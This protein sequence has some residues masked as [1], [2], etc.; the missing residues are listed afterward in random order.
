MALTQ[1]VFDPSDDAW[2][3]RGVPNGNYGGSVDM[4]IRNRYGHPSHPDIWETYLFVRFDISSIPPGSPIESARLY[5][6]LYRRWESDPT[7]RNLNIYLVKKDWDESTV[8]FANQPVCLADSSGYARVSPNNTWM[9]WDVTEELQA[10]VNQT[11]P[12]YGW[13]LMDNTR[14]GNFNIPMMYFY[15][16][17]SGSH[18]PYLEVVTGA[19][20]QAPTAVI[21]HIHPNPARQGDTISFGGY[22]TDSDG[23]VVA[24]SW[25]SSLDGHLSSQPSFSTCGLSPGTHEIHFIVQDNDGIWSDEDSQILEIETTSSLPDRERIGLL[26]NEHALSQNYPNP[27]NAT[28][29]IRYSL[30]SPQRVLLQVFNMLGQEVAV[31]AN[32]FQKVGTYKVRFDA[33]NLSSGIY[34]Y[35]LTTESYSECRKMMLMK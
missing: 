4:V 15:S 3:N 22:G 13:K 8:T 12:N 24:Y 20:N 23:F 25:S 19:S 16:K 10:F 31:L 21:D 30:P 35:R 2:V 18:R 6:D 11:L 17:E 27:F 1:G 26:P 28:T 14:W 7:G 34:F 5:L 29:E 32:E 9:V 33:T